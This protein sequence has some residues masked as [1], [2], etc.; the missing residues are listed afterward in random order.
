MSHLEG[1][2]NNLVISIVMVQSC[3]CAFMAINTKMWLSANKFDEFVAEQLTPAAE[4]SVLS[5]FTY[6]LLLNTLLPI[7]LQVAFEVC[8]MVQAYFITQDALMFSWEREKLV[9]VQTA[10]IVEDL[11]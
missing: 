6:F 10:S 4:I 8:K 1:Q 7:S 9:N 11:G 3:L 5:F 2:I